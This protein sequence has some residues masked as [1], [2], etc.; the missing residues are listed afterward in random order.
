MKNGTAYLI[1]EKGEPYQPQEVFPL[2][3]N[4][5]LIGRV[6]NNHHPDL[7]F[8]DQSISRS[9]AEIFV[10]DGRYFIQDI[11]RNGTKIIDGGPRLGKDELYEL[12]HGNRISLAG[13]RVLMTFNWGAQPGDTM[14]IASNTI[15]IILDEKKKLVSV[16]GREVYLS[17]QSYIL[18]R[19]LYDNRGEIVS[20]QAIIETI[21]PGEDGVLRGSEEVASLIRRLRYEL[22]SNDIIKT[23]PKSGYKLK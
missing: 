12:K 2:L 15:E 8:S 21:W 20:H 17:N 5:I 11:S 14:P 9:H 23:V 19:L 7:A 10:K 18:F 3:R 16:E 6:W 13:G 1:I 22:G 4:K